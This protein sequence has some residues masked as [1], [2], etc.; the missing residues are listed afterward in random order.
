MKI[1]IIEDEKELNLLIKSILEK[2]GFEVDSFFDGESL[3]QKDKKYDLYLID[4]NLPK[5]NGL[6]LLDLI[7]GKKMVISANLNPKIID[8]AYLKGIEDFIKKP[9]IKE[10]FLHKIYKIFPKKVKIKEYL[11]MPNERILQKEDKLIILTQDEAKFL[12]LF[13]KKDIVTF[14]EIKNNIQK[15]NNALY[16]FLSKLKKKTGIDFE[17]IKNLGYKIKD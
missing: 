10:E 11:L 15:E 8:K 16:V 2:E 12:S 4:L 7:N 5:V 17:N 9:F 1:A 14:E 3:L 13:A 6:D